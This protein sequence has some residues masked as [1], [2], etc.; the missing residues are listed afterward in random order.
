M[1]ILTR[2]SLVCGF[3]STAT[4]EALVVTLLLY[5]EALKLV[6]IDK[7]RADIDPLTNLPLKG[8]VV[9]GKMA[10]FRETTVSISRT[11]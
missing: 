6:G 4:E 1:P 8:L 7:T 11:R 3:C 10:W 9:A 2:A 5:G